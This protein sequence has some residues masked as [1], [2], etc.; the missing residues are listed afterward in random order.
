MR[1]EE[2]LLTPDQK[3]SGEAHEA[4]KKPERDTRNQCQRAKN[5]W[6]KKRTKAFCLTEVEIE[7]SSG[8]A[9]TERSSE[10]VWYPEKSDRDI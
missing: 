10:S 7:P 6:E 8:N 5:G 2:A 3:R 1:F 9:E 4:V